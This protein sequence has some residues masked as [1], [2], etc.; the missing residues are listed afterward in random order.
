LENDRFVDLFKN[1][2]TP[3]VGLNNDVFLHHL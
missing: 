3:D 1:M 2:A